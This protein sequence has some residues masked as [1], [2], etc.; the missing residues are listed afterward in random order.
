MDLVSP[1]DTVLLQRFFVALSIGALI[2]VEREQHQAG[3][4]APFGGVR[5]FTLVAIVGAVA[6]WLA[7]ELDAPSVIVAGF[8]AV[9]A[10]AVAAHL[11]NLRRDPSAGAT[12][13]V[14]ALVTYAL[15]VAS[16]VG[17]PEMAVALG[18]VTTGLLAFKDPMHAAIGRLSREDVQAALQLLFASFVVLPVLPSAPID[19]WGALAPQALWLLVVLISA[20]SM[21]GYVAVRWLGPNR[22][23]PLTG[24]LAGLVSSTALTLAF[25]R[26]SREVPPLANVLA[27]GV[28]LSWTVMFARVLVEALVVAPNVALD[29]ALPMSVLALVAVGVAGTLAWGSGAGGE[30][31]PPVALSS[32]FSLGAA[33]RFA[34]FY[35]LIL[36]IVAVVRHELD[37]RW[38]YAVAVLAGTTD[39]DAITLSMARLGTDPGQQEVAVRAIV[40]AVATNTLVKAGIVAALG[41]RALRI[42]LG[43]ATGLLIGGAIASLTGLAAW[44]WAG[45]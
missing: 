3:D 29:L 2:G 14:A 37:P 25:A 12:T 43:I 38:L 6:G 4:A 42:R 35:A 40:V 15:G 32:P 24:A 28:L 27:V 16:V 26:R 22:G 45:G 41:E 5:T 1:V 21:T 20:I 30:G 34:A 13:E 8:A 19:P 10:L 23:I 44:G 11:P 17:A 31:P 39:V 18:I 7:R 33:V 9:A 36:F